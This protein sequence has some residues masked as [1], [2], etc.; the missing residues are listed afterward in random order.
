M[1]KFF[2]EAAPAEGEKAIEEIYRRR[3]ELVKAAIHLPYME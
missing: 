3:S 2:A 1:K